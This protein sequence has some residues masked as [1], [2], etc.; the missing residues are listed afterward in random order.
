[1]KKKCEEQRCPARRWELPL[2]AVIDLP[3]RR[4]ALR[5]VDWPAVLSIGSPRHRSAHRVVDWFAVSLIFL[6]SRRVAHILINWPAISSIG[7]P[8]QGLAPHF[9]DW[10][11]ASSMGPTFRRLPRRLV[12]WFV[13]SWIGPTSRRL[14]S[15]CVDWLL[16]SSIGLTSHGL[17]SHFVDW[18][19]VHGFGVRSCLCSC[20]L[21]VDVAERRVVGTDSIGRCIHAIFTAFA[22][23]VA[24]TDLNAWASHLLG[25][26]LCSSCH[27]PRSKKIDAAHIPLE[28]GGAC[29]GGWPQLGVSWGRWAVEIRRRDQ[30]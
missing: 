23:W 19:V 8:S 18:L 22:S 11:V 30:P 26:P 10:L 25:P 5:I 1:M 15:R 29:L 16:A 3:H 2:H 12:N 24:L 20:L 7:L 17:A 21:A 27:T 9:V 4:W 13:V 6:R 28:R 14:A